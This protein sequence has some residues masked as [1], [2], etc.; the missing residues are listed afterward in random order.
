MKRTIA[1]CLT[2]LAL[3][4]A[5]PVAAQPRIDV[6]PV[7]GR[8]EPRDPDVDPDLG[9][10]VPPAPTP[11]V[12]LPDAPPGELALPEVHARGRIVVHAEAGLAEL[13]AR[14]AVRADRDLARIAGDLPG[15]AVPARVEIRVVRDAAD[16]PRAAPPGRGAPVW[17]A[18]VAYPDLGVLV[19]ALHRGGT[20]LDIEHT[21][22]HE[23]AHLAL[24][25]ALG[26]RAPHWLHEG[27]AWQHSPDLG[28]DRA[29]TLAG[30]AWLGSVIPLD[31]LDASFP[32]AELPASRAYAESYDFVSF[33]ARRGRWDDRADDGD[34]WP[35]R[36]FLRYT[37]AGGT[38][39]EAA[40]KA[41][42]RPLAVLFDEWRADLR[43]RYFY[44]PAAALVGALWLIAAVLLVLAWLRRRRQSKR[45][46]GE[47]GEQER[48]ADADAASTVAPPPF[49]AWPGQNDPL[50]EP[51]PTASEL[52]VEYP[53]ALVAEAST[54]APPDVVDE[55][56]D[57][58][59]DDRPDPPRRW[60]N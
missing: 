10:D 58:D 57:E 3:L 30:M 54:D 55:D 13:A 9:R 38:L 20:P 5:A 4:V 43:G 28:M 60:I 17:A 25:A 56:D 39:D 42:G 37:A 34:R 6:P 33:L 35:F 32:A 23:L 36:R 18:G 53:D 26:D 11:G 47:W 27:F 40:V 45:R 15:L 2:A 12:V 48:R 24:G 8:A 52:A 14:L 41:Y 51:A 29:E 59:D 46:L 31:R 22:T 49:V 19:L 7:A 50:A 21:A 44:F 1:T 16:M